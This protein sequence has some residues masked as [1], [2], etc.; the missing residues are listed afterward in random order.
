MLPAIAS[1]IWSWLGLGFSISSAAACMIWPAWQK[2]HCGTL[3]WRQ[4]FWTAWS[5]GRMQTFDRGDLAADHVGDR[6]DAGAYRL[7][8]DD[9]GA[10]AAQRLAAAVFRAGQSGFVAEEP[11]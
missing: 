5:P 4:A 2:P 3:T 10:G 8:V 9:H 11:E 1:R 6:R 7:L